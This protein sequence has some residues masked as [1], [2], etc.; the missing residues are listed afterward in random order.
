MLTVVLIVAAWWIKPLLPAVVKYAAVPTRLTK[1]MDILVLGVTPEYL[2]YHKRAPQ[3]FGGLTDTIMLVR[4]D[5][6][7]KRVVVLS[8]PRDTF[9]Q[10]PGHGTQRINT[11]NPYG[12]PAL[13]EQVV[14]TLT[15]VTS[16][17]YILVDLSAF[18]DAVNALGGVRVCVRVPMN[19]TDNAAGLYIH[20]K[21]GCQVLNGDNA[22]AY[23]RFRH[24]ALGDIG[25]I[26]RQQAFL[27]AA[28]TEL[29]APTGLLRLPKVVEA[30]TNNVRTNLTRKQ[31]GQILGF[32]RSAPHV[33]SLLLPGNFGG[34]GWVANPN[35]I[36]EVVRTYFQQSAV[37]TAAPLAD[38]KGKRVTVVYGI[39]DLP[40]AIELR[41][42]LGSLGLQV[43]FEQVK[44]APQTS[45]VLA[46][47]EAALAQALAKVLKLPWRISGQASLDTDLTVW[48][49]TGYRPS[50][51]AS[52]P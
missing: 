7:M 27:H 32:A 6:A 36:A 4:L 1:P 18:R 34:S 26:Q 17:A 11:A 8:I 37:P 35:K 51:A 9:V 46:N 44:Q 3:S 14:Y 25:R 13:A 19:Y 29:L 33:D 21:P 23:V 10:M 49:G 38:L 24:D 39:K 2:G 47:G 42:K 45:T 16:N 43:V 30:I 31:I 28:K 50:Q 41:R 20:L 22:E 48:I 40:I 12:G 52:K 15:G 5:P